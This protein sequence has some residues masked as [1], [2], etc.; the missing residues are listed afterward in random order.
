MGPLT[1]D[2]LSESHLHPAPT[3]GL[4]GIIWC[5]PENVDL[6]AIKVVDE[7]FNRIHN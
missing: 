2:Y 5:Q 4:N 7:N 6:L 1:T 3:P